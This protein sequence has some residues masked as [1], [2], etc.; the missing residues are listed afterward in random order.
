MSLLEVAPI[1]TELLDDPRAAAPSVRESLRN[2][3]RANRWL[4]GAAALRYALGRVITGFRDSPVSLLDIGTGTGDLPRMARDWAARRGVTLVP[5]GIELSGVAA[6]LARES[7]VETV[8]G[9]GGSLPFRDRSVDLILISQVAHHFSPAA[10]VRLFREAAR[11]ARHAVLVSDLRRSRVAAWGFPLAGWALR[12]DR[13]TRQD[14]VTSLRRG[15]TRPGLARL[16]EQAGLPAA[17]VRR[18]GF[19][20]VAVAPVPGPGI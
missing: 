8:V 9:D 11:V 5:L 20:L 16:L 12:F 10:I 17:V 4:G 13:F 6:R 2:I 7:G 3:A 19:R 15:F 14:G 18:P 1:G